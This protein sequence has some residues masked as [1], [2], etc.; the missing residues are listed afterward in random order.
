MHLNEKRV[1]KVDQCVVKIIPKISF[2]LSPSL[3]HGILM[4]TCQTDDKR[5]SVYT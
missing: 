2:S 4:Y 1:E 3:L 5:I